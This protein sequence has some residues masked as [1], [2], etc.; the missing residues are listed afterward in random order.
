MMCVRFL[1]VL[2][3]GSLL[4]QGCA[5]VVIGSAA[6]ATKTATDPRT[7]GN[8][9]DDSTLALRVTNAL[10]RDQQLRT[11]ARIDATVWQGKILLVGQAP[12]PALAQRAKKIT[13]E[14]P[15]AKE[16]YN[17]IRVGE[18]INLST[19][20]NDTWLATKV[21]TKLLAN[22]KVKFANIKVTAENGEIFLMGSVT[23]SEADIAADITSRIAGVKHVVMAFTLVNG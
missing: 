14:V 5:A 23:Q 20:S 16:V 13:S 4:L 11:Q 17:E 1:I 22:D 18:K 8:Q 7:L 15:G 12:E 19:I 21:R 6:V 2:V 9:V 10:A 3:A